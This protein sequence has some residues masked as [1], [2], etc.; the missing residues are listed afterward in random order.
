MQAI[1]VIIPLYNSQKFL[2][3]A[4]AS[5]A[6]QTIKNDILVTLVDDNSTDDYSQIIEK[7]SKSLNI[8]YLRLKR[9][10]GPGKARQIAI[11]QTSNYY[12]VFLDSDDFYIKEDAL[13]KMLKNIQNFQILIAE[14]I[15]DDK[16]VKHFGNLHAKLYLRK[17]INKNKIKFPKIDYGEDTVFNMQYILSLPAEKITLIPD[18]IY[19]WQ[20]INPASLTTKYSKIFDYNIIMKK[21][22]KYLKN[23]NNKKYKLIYIEYLLKSIDNIY[24]RITNID[25]KVIF[26]KKYCWFYKAFIAE[27]NQITRLSNLP[28]VRDFALYYRRW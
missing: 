9:H 14:E 6:K 7:Y 18:T 26:C 17:V 2:P 22:Y 4:L 24:K 23:T 13:E 21:V 28:I 5:L 3:T 19:K 8:N 10:Q 12:I 27:I 1:D 20:K 16:S 25:E 11:S 15:I